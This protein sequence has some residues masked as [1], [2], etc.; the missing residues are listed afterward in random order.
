D[1]QDAMREHFLMGRHS[2][3]DC[4]YL[5]QTYARIPKH[6]MRDNANLLI[7][8]RQDGTNLRHVCNVHVNTDMTFEEFVALCRDCWRRRY[9]FF[10]IDK[11]SALR[12]GRYRRGFTE[13]ALS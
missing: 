6:L 13:Y 9:G 1:T 8:F 3:V 4:F 11:D 2:L 10:V 5:C 7:L 12:N